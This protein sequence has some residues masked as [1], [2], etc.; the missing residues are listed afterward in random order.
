MPVGA[1][2]ASQFT[3]M[4]IKTARIDGQGEYLCLID[5]RVENYMLPDQRRPLPTTRNTSMPQRKTCF[6]GR[7]TGVRFCFTYG[8]GNTS[9]PAIANNELR[10][11]SLKY[12]ENTWKS[13]AKAG[14][15]LLLFSA[16]AD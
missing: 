12:A 9:C 3:H 15:L 14:L 11:S 6:T 1:M 7:R 4:A 10:K 2:L 16:D 8:P 5:A 13:D